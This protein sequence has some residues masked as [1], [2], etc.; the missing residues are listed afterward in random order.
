MTSDNSSPTVSVLCRRRRRILL[1]LGF[2]AAVFIVGCHIR[3][4]DE[5]FDGSLAGL[6]SGSYYGYAARGFDAHGFVAMRMQPALF[7]QPETS[8]TWY[9]YVNHPFTP[10]LLTYP[11]WRFGGRDER[12]LRMP[13]LALLIVTLVATFLAVGRH[14][15]TLTAGGSLAFLATTPH[16]LQYGN[17]VDAPPFSLAIL[18]PTVAAWL[19][20]RRLPGGGRYL[21][22][23]ACAFLAGSLDW[24]SA[25][26][27]PGLVVDAFFARD[28]RGRR[29]RTAMLAALPFGLAFLGYVAWITWIS[30]GIGTA[31]NRLSNLLHVPVGAESGA[32][33]ADVSFLAAMTEWFERGFGVP[34]LVFVAIGLAAIVVRLARRRTR[35]IDRFALI[36]FSVGLL[37][38]LVFRQRAIV[39]EF[40]ILV[41]T[42]GLAIVAAVGLRTT[43]DLTDHATRRL[44]SRLRGISFVIAI[45]VV[46]FVAVD[47]ARQGIALHDSFRTDVHRIRGEALS[48]LLGPGDVIF[49]V[50]DIGATRYYCDGTVIIAVRSLEIFDEAL[51]HL[52]FGRTAVDRLFLAA[53]VDALGDLSWAMSLPRLPMTAREQTL[54]KSRYAM[55]EL[56]VKRCF[57]RVEGN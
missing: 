44:G 21:V 18:V 46:G 31:W 55:T 34:L 45:G 15:D 23:V 28:A 27:G 35:D 7:Y 32:S 26:I 3:W 38:S 39:H 2:A 19:R 11:A 57:A 29:R 20:Y 56:D 48:E 16:L 1:G 8:A 49:F 25:L 9:A 5:P 10:H 33:A 43:L 6:T 37:P 17:M 24:F 14:G 42:P 41:A 52:S 51:R 50:T 36:V 54:G 4:I 47:G 40:W 53:P 30:G 13:I 12:A 22:Y